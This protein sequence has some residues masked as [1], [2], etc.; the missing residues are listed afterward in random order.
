M[1]I[2]AFLDMFGDDYEKRYADSAGI[3]VSLRSLPSK[4]LI[5]ILK[6]V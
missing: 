1:P 4:P 6:G 3:K 5:Y 2:E